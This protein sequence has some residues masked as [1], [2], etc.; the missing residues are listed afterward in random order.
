[1]ST[2]KKTRSKRK[3]DSSSFCNVSCLNDLISL[4]QNTNNQDFKKIKQIIKEIQSLNELVGLSDLK[5]QIIEQIMFFVQGFATNEMMHTC[6]MGPPGV[7]KTTVAEIIAKIYSK[8]GFLSQGNFI[9]VGREHLIGQYL[10]ETAQKT[11]KVLRNSIGSVLFIDEAYSLGNSHRDDMYAKE[12]IDTLNQFLSENTKNFVCII[13]GYEE[14][15]NSCFFAQNPGL[16]RRF[17]WKYNIEKYTSINLVDIFKSMLTRSKWKLRQPHDCEE[18]LK[19]IIDQNLLYFDN[20]GGDISNFITF[21]KMIHSR[22]MFG[23]KRTWKRYLIPHD[24][25]QGFLLFKKNKKVKEKNPLIDF[26]YI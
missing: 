26:M 21:C 3:L 16:E 25:Y 7:G 20:G 14:Q 5:N 11:K 18:T 2:L 22:R 1:M 15:L 9:K 19:N 12:C 10:G 8:L 23:A 17:P 4:A 24:I 6:L 13:A